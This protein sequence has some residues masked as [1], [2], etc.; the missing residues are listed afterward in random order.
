MCRIES[1]PLYLRESDMLWQLL[2]FKCIA[3]LERAAMQATRSS[4]LPLFVWER[5][6]NLAPYLTAFPV[7]QYEK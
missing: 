7:V 4:A 6:V 3:L 2:S 5:R 1:P